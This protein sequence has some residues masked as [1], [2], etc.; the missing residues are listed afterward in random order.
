[1]NGFSY[2]TGR[3]KIYEYMAV[4]KQVRYRKENARVPLWNIE[5]IGRKQ[6]GIEFP[7]IIELV[8]YKDNR[9]EVYK[10]L[11]E[12]LKTYCDKIVYIDSDSVIHTLYQR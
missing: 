2:V 6:F 4:I 9:L 11:I 12:D 7:D 3:N 10:R 8:N 1:M 5:T